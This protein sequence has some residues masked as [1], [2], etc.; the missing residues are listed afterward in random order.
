MPAAMARLFFE[1]VEPWTG[2]RTM[3]L[4]S[5]S[6]TG[7]RSSTAPTGTKPP[8]SA[9][10]ESSMSGSTPQCSIAHMRPVRPRPVWISS[11][12]KSVPWRRHSAAASR[13]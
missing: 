1:K 12:T 2:A 13:R 6:K 4:K 11:A 8:E 3:L 9:F 7:L 5:E 10:A